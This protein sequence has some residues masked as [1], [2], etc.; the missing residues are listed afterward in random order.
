MK[1]S[2]LKNI[3]REEIQNILEKKFQYTRDMTS[4]PK[5]GDIVKGLP[6][7]YVNGDYFMVEKELNS[8]PN[9]EY[10]IYKVGWNDKLGD[11]L[12]MSILPIHARHLVDKFAKSKK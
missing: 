2:E 5:K 11:A 12:D 8:P 9:S 6:V 4:P 1:R 7:T 10:Y 3:I